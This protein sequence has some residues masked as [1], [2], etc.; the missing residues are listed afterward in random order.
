MKQLIINLVAIV[1]ISI[2]GFT[3]M[4]AQPVKAE[5]NAVISQSSALLFAECK[6][7]DIIVSGNKC[8]V[9]DGHCYCEDF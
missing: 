3:L 1:I 7:G 9:R 2:G 5:T 6:E 8:G 4:D